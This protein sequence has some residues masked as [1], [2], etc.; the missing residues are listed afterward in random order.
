MA[1]SYHEQVERAIKCAPE[2]MLG[3]ELEPYLMPFA[4]EPDEHPVVINPDGF[5]IDSGV[6]V[7]TYSNQY[8]ALIRAAMEVTTG[9]VDG[10]FMEYAV[11]H[12]SEHAQAAQALG[13]TAGMFG[14]KFYHSRDPSSKESVVEFRPFFA[15]DNLRTTKLGSAL[16][17][18]YPERPSDGDLNDVKAHGYR[19]IEEI[20]V[21][22]M[23][24]NA[25]KQPDERFLPVPVKGS[26]GLGR[27]L[28][29]ASAYESLHTPLMLR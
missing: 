2:V 12:E 16:L 26:G 15:V 3:A 9:R 7:P 28:Q 29:Y 19:G 10:Y 11:Q 6:W 8:R 21:R 14:V 18:G 27:K 1:V 17:A 20:T 4:A 22:A 24:R 5:H 25:K 23:Q 13:A